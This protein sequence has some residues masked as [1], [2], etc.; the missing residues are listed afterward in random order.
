MKIQKS[1][2]IK[3][4]VADPDQKIRDAAKMYEQYFLNEM[5]KSMRKTVDHSKLNEPTM[6][7]KIYSEQ[8]DTQYVEKWSDSGGVGLA[9]IIYNKLLL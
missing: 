1:I 8:L 4:Q 2:D 9:D 5:M 3:Q 6:A 7:Q